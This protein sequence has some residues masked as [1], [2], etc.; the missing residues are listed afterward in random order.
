MVVMIIAALMRI[1]VQHAAELHDAPGKR[2]AYARH[3]TGR[4]KTPQNG[5]VR[6]YLEHVGFSSGKDIPVA[7]EI[8]HGFDWEIIV[9]GGLAKFVRHGR[10]SRAQRE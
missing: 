8:E 10:L 9:Q 3:T 6:H 2:A 1:G 5:Q 7:C 4:W